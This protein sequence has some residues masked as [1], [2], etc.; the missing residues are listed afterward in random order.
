MYCN[1]VESCGFYECVRKVC[2]MFFTQ[3]LKLSLLRIAFVVD[4]NMITAV[5][6]DASTHQV[7]PVLVI[8]RQLISQSL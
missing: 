7:S 6:S 3:L 5:K 1:S 4:T 8:S 2:G